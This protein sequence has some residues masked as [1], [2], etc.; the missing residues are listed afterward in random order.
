MLTLSPRLGEL[1]T[2]ATETPDIETALWKVLSEY[3]DL[4]FNELSKQIG[5]FEQKWGMSFE[6]FSRRC[7]ERDLEMDA[8]SYEVENDFWAWE[9]A[10]TLRRHYEALRSKWM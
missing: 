6:E 2:K 4:K 8:Y 10:M 5:V 9:K 7:K 1:L 3:L